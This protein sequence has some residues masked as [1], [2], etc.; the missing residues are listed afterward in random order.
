MY[1]A[2][3]AS[4]INRGVAR[5]LVERFPVGLLLGCWASRRHNPQG[6]TRIARAVTSEIIGYDVL[7]G[8]R[9]ASRLDVQHVSSEVALAET[10]TTERAEV[11][12]ARS[13]EQGEGRASGLRS[14]DTA[15]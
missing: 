8:V 3:L 4:V 14:S 2:R 5:P 9:P 10:E 15:T 13:G 7:R 6:S 11:R 1:D 12:G